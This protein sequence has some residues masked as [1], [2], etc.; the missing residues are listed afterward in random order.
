MYVVQVYTMKDL[1]PLQFFRGGAADVLGDLPE[2]KAEQP[3]KPMTK[4]PSLLFDME[5]WTHPCLAECSSECLIIREE[6][7]WS[8]ILVFW[9][10]PVMGISGHVAGGGARAKRSR[11]GSP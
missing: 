4:V 2:R 3:K 9:D 1:N 7:I 11:G 8:S 10:T 6:I 5:V